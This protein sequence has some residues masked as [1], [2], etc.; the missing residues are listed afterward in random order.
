VSIGSV[1]QDG[2]QPT[3]ANAARDEKDA[4]V[5]IDGFNHKFAALHLKMDHAG[6]LAMW[7]DDGVDPCPVKTR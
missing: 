5:E 2:R 7:A 1:S 4:K 6:I 3:Q